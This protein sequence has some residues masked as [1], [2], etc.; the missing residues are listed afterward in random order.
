MIVD[1]RETV[2]ICA[3]VWLDDCRRGGVTIQQLRS[4]G[5]GWLESDSGSFKRL[6]ESRRPRTRFHPGSQPAHLYCIC[7]SSQ[8]TVHVK[9]EQIKS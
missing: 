5:P 8:P 7:I 3:V 6:S 1:E 2:W 9:P 4:A